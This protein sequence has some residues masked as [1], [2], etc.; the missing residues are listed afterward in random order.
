MGRLIVI[1]GLDGSGKSTQVSL[2][3][4]SLQARGVD[5]RAIKLPNYEDDSSALVRMYLAGAFGSRAEDLT[6][7]AASSFY[8]VDRIASFCKDWRRDYEAGRLILADR[9]TTSN[10]IYQM[11]KLP[12]AAW[13]EYLHW[14]DDFEYDKLGLP[15]P[16]CV[17][18]L[19]VPLARSRELLD[20]RYHGDAA[21]RDIHERDAQYLERCHAAAQYAIARCG[22][23]RIDCMRAGAL[24]SVEDIQAEILAC[25]PL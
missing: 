21:K 17:L 16:D 20:Q 8:A 5:C 4:A 18:Y 12:E 24:R 2:L 7:Y 9:Y 3:P 15:R 1:E 13:E 14:L 22:W 25:L 10:C 19:D 11:C 23:R 6:A